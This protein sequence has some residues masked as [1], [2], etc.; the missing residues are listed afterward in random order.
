MAEQRFLFQNFLDDKKVYALNQGFWE[1]QLN[2]L[3]PETDII[4]KNWINN[5]YANRKK[6]YDGNPIYNVLIK[7]DKAIRII[8]EKPESDQPEIGAWM[9]KTENDNGEPIEELVISLELSTVTKDI[10]VKL[11]QMWSKGILNV[12]EIEKTIDQIGNETSAQ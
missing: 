4:A 9:Q 12:D 3:L 10:A 1:R 7:P 8:Q 11:I 2:K 6:I 5:L